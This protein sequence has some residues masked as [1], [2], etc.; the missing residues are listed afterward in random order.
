[1]LLLQR[2]AHI[3]AGVLFAVLVPR[4]MGPEIYGRYA[5]ITAVAV[6]LAILSSL[7][8]TNAIGRYVPELLH[9]GERS[10]LR[11]LIGGLLSLRL[12]S[13][14]GAAVLYFAIMAVWLR[15]VDV[16]VLALMAVS[17]FVHSL[18]GYVFAL[19][20]GFDE[21]A[22]WGMSEILRRWLSLVLVI[23]GFAL[24]GLIGASLAV[25]LTDLALL[26]LGLR[27]G[28][29]HLS[30]AEL[31]LG[32][33]SLMPYLRFGL[34]FFASHALGIAFQASGEPLVRIASGDY[35]QVSYFALAHN[36]YLAA[37]GVFPQLTLAFVPTL[38]RLVSD[39][40]SREVT[41]WVD[42]LLTWLTIASMAALFGT[43]MLADTF[44]P[45]VLGGAYAAVAP[46][47]PP[48]MLALLMLGV[49]NVT[50]LLTIVHERPG[51]ALAASAL[52]LGVFWAAGPPCVAWYG[53]SLGACLAVLAASTAHAA[54]S[55]WRLRH[56]FGASLRSAAAAAALSVVFLP[57]VLLKVSAVVNLSLYGLFVAAYAL[58][59]L[60]T[61][62]VSTGEIAEMW[63]AVRG[64]MSA[65]E[66]PP[67][68][69]RPTT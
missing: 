39:G 18:T 3:A 4:M 56:G 14:G 43:L 44:V 36:A 16:P 22:R 23:P 46:N 38:T 52:R 5:L 9:R 63:R 48:L 51:V 10:E 57:L 64:R 65:E 40:A 27:W 55:V 37:A 17:V 33:A 49:G 69:R 15:D 41:A 12:L 59:L 8:V 67:R 42:R 61:G 68:A 7:G 13:G 66:A 21:A 47:L 11:R 2:G 30:P 58:V 35:A 1:L 45:L 26:G 62:I 20:L 19:F 6:A 28:R 50:V 60:W 34:L 31:Q 24:G 25:L 32:L 29:L 54:F 53:G